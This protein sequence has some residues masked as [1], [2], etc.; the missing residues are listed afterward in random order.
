MSVPT[1]MHH[2]DPDQTLSKTHQLTN[3]KTIVNYKYKLTLLS[4]GRRG[5]LTSPMQS[6]QVISKST[7]IRKNPRSKQN[8]HANLL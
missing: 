5:F 2:Y 1:T 6:V 7:I 8:P 3:Y 4:P